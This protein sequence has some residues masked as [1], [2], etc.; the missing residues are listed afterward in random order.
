MGIIHGRNVHK[1]TGKAIE[2]SKIVYFKRSSVKNKYKSC[3][4][5][6]IIIMKK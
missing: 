2:N 1:P 6:I 4:K 3:S 5:K